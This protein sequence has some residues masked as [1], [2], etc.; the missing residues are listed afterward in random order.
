MYSVK[1][2]EKYTLALSLPNVKASVTQLLK[3]QTLTLQMILHYFTL[4]IILLL[5]LEAAAEAVG[6]HVNYKKTEYIFYCSTT[7]LV[8]I[9]LPNQETDWS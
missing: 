9:L 4:E 2:Q 8:V 3:S 5:R 6:L 1:Q 7:K